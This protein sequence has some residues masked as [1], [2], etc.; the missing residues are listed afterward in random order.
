[1]V[2]QR[3]GAAKPAVQ[4][5][6]AHVEGCLDPIKHVVVA[7]GFPGPAAFLR[8]SRR[9]R[10]NTVLEEAKRASLGAGIEIAPILLGTL[11]SLVGEA[12]EAS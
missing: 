5:F 2:E 10:P 7:G 8:A 3:I 12:L 4:V 11:S 1:M 9:F 6:D